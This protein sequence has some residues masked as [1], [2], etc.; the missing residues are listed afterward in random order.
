M[1]NHFGSSSKHGISSYLQSAGTSAVLAVFTDIDISVSNI[2]HVYV[3]EDSLC[4]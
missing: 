2:V 1:I 4:N 3:C